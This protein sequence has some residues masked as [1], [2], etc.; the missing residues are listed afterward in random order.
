MV[1]IANLKAKEKIISVKYPDSDFEVEVRYLDRDRLVRI[2]NNST[3]L[4]WNKNSREREETTDNDKFLDLYAKEAI[5]S[6]TGLTVDLLKEL[7]VLDLPE[8]VDLSEEVE[9]NEE[10]ALGLFQNSSSF[11]QFITD[12]MADIES[13]STDKKE[14]AV[15]N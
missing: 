6:W 3:K 14:K 2:R 4:K 10:N 8:D 7:M 11:D 12:V 15:K 1:S 9:Y 5:V 13:F